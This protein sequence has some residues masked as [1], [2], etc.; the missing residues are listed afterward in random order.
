MRGRN[1]LQLVNIKEPQLLKLIFTNIE[2]GYKLI[3]F[4]FNDISSSDGCFNETEKFCIYFHVFVFIR[5]NFYN[6]TL[7]Q[8]KNSIIN[9]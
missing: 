4:Y 8:N 1:T 7:N 2:I 9:T 6:L 3:S 5:Y